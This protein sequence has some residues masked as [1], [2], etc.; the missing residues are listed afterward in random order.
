VGAWAVIANLLNTL[1]GA[2]ILG[3]PNSF[4]LCGFIPGVLM[5]TLA[6]ILSYF[7]SVIVVRL[8]NRTEL[9]NMNEISERFLGNVA[10]NLYS[11]LNLVDLS[12]CQ[13]AYLDVGSDV[14]SGWFEMFGLRGW[15]V[16]WKR[17]LV[18]F[19]YSL[20]IPVALTIPRNISVISAAS[21][22]STIVLG[23]YVFVMICEGA[24]H[25]GTEGISPT[26]SNW[27]LGMNSINAFSI[28]TTTFAI[29]AVI[30]PLMGQFDRNVRRRFGV[31]GNS[32][33][34]CWLLVVIP[35][36]IGYLIFGV[37]C[38][39]DV[40]SS[41]DGQDL[42]IQFARCS[43]F[44]VLNA[45]YPVMAF[46]MSCE[47]STLFFSHWNAAVL[48]FLKRLIVLLVVNVPVVLIAM[49]MPDMRPILEIGGALGGC[50]CNFVYPPLLWFLSRE[51]VP[52]FSLSRLPMIIFAALGVV[53]AIL[54]IRQAS[55]DAFELYRSHE[56]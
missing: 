10:G 24:M 56:S 12:C 14:I 25:L 5:L 2:E 54:A 55:V 36:S 18:V 49:L 26:A 45:S 6:A 19:I 44:I 33:I 29:P 8:G 32:F 3:I 15:N 23:I 22:A 37:M 40:L 11:I 41:F 16:G 52:W 1:I 31:L 17:P 4:T 9:D 13:I 27:I 42:M 43:F 38:D 21:T 30:L 50:M 39:Q 46:V 47:V 35:S 53:C 48:P 20:L 7:S 28:Y 51:G 34:I